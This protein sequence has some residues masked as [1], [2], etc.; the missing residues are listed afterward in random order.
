[1]INIGD[2]FL[3]KL[4]RGYWGAFKVL[5]RG[6]SFFDSEA[7]G[8]ELLM[9]GLLDI[10]SAEKPLISD[11]RLA[12]ILCK[13]RFWFDNQYDLNFVVADEKYNN[14][15]THEL[16]GNLPLTQF[17][18]NVAFKLGHGRDGPAGG[19]P[20][21][22]V[23]DASY[24]Y[25]AFLEWR[26]V[27]EHDALV[28]EV[29]DDKQ[30]RIEFEK[31]RVM[32]PKKMMSDDTF[33]S[34][35][36]LLDWKAD[37][38]DGTVKPVIRHLAKLKVV[39]IRQFEETLAFKLYALD[40]RLHAS[41][42]G[43]YAYDAKDDYVS[44]DQFLYARCAVVVNGQACYERALKNPKHMLKDLDF[45]PLI[46]VAAEAYALKTKKDFD[47]TTGC[48]KE[49]FSNKAGWPRLLP[50]TLKSASQNA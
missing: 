13:K 19:I 7:S 47:Y 32:T 43:E 22:G 31:N 48:D 17:E 50:P 46:Y 24:G 44:A 37:D 40:T 5:Q 33:W 6:P 14:I 11:E 23:V 29:E 1:M 36:A 45:E 4:E 27:H 25:N 8:D 15:A 20:H 41:H 38:N 9:L 10:M 26:W 16:L 34:I 39:D 28:Q 49:T 12:S 30:K 18:R 3:T 2:V 21:M 35:I 42:I